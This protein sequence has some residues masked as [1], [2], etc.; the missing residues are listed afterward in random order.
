MSVDALPERWT[1]CSIQTDLHNGALMKPYLVY[2]LLLAIIHVS[3]P[4]E[5]LADVFD[6]GGQPPRSP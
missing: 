5:T 4:V 6:G 2:S 1:S 3:G